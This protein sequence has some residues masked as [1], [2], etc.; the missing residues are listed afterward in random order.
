MVRILGLFAIIPVTIL[1]T[2][3]FF[4]LFTLGK[5]TSKGIRNLGICVAI[6]LWISALLVSS[7]GIYTLVTGKHPMMQIMKH[8]MMQNMIMPPG[9]MSNMQAIPN[10]P[11]MPRQGT[12]PQGMMN[13][14]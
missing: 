4:V 7:L 3:S 9:P 13:R 8:C 5:V 6:L 2:V 10:M 12:M 14:R 11:A 1:L